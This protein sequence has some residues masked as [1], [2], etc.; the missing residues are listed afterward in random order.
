[1]K[2]AN[3]L[4]ITLLSFF[5]IFTWAHNFLA[6]RFDYVSQ[7]WLMN[8]RKAGCA[9]SR[10]CSQRTSFSSAAPGH[11]LEGTFKCKNYRSFHR[12]MRWLWEW[13]PFNV[14]TRQKAGLEIFGLIWEREKNGLISITGILFCLL[15]F[16]LN[17]CFS[18]PILKFKHILSPWAGFSFKW[19]R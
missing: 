6:F 19:G 14:S 7:F 12:T 2:G 4:L 17:F 15:W 13:K 8:I 11:C 10:K 3:Y 16:Y 18:S 5:S 1:M 9:T